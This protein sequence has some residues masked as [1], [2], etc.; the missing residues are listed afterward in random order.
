MLEKS[1]YFGFRSQIA[2]LLRLGGKP[3]AKEKQ[4]QEQSG[5]GGD[6]VKNGGHV[7]LL[8]YRG[9]GVQGDCT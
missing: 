4:G 6:Q 9:V 1:F 2:G 5:D 8:L 3:D 7:R